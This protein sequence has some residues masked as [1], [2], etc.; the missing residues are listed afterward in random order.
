V[1]QARQPWNIWIEQP[2]ERVFYRGSP[3]NWNENITSG[4]GFA[5]KWQRRSLQWISEMADEPGCAAV[6]C[7]HDPA[8]EPHIIE[9]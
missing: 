1:K 2:I 9:F 4:F 3:R 8:I 6:L 7:S 5:E